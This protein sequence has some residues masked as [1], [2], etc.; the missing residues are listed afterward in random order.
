MFGHSQ[1][2]VVA[3]SYSVEGAVVYLLTSVRPKPRRPTC[4]RNCTTVQDRCG[5]VQRL[6]KGM[7]KE[8][9]H[10]IWQGDAVATS[11]VTAIISRL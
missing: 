9:R 1:V 8:V 10:V 11:S 4:A 6:C 3:S 7:D 2:A 5:E